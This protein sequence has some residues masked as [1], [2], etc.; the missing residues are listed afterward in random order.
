MTA[1]H[2]ATSASHYSPWT[3][4]SLTEGAEFSMRL[5]L[6]PGPAGREVGGHLIT[7]LSHLGGKGG[8]PRGVCGEVE[9]GGAGG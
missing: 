1:T 4:K 2:R 6:F 8:E 5:H 9:E 7:P 3:T